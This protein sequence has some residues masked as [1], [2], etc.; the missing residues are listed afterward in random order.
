M[1]VSKITSKSIEATIVAEDKTSRTDLDSYANMPVVAIA[2][3]IKK[4][5]NTRFK[6]DTL[7]VSPIIIERSGRV[8]QEDNTSKASRSVSSHSFG[9]CTRNECLL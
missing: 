5:R 4:T 6:R 8:E 1:I 9:F 2:K 3:S 7:V